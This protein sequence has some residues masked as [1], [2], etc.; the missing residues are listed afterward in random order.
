MRIRIQL[1]PPIDWKTAKTL[2]LP[3][4]AVFVTAAGSDK[5]T[6]IAC[7][8]KDSTKITAALTERKIAHSTT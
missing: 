8:Q 5:I 1:T 7:N 2:H 3:V 6:S 4:G